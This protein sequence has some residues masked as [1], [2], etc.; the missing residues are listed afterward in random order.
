M[1]PHNNDRPSE[2]WVLFIRFPT[3]K[4]R[5]KTWF[6]GMAKKE[7][8]NKK[9]NNV[10]TIASQEDLK[11]IANTTGTHNREHVCSFFFFAVLLSH[12]KS[13]SRF[14]NAPWIPQTRERNLSQGCKGRWKPRLSQER[15]CSVLA[16]PNANSTMGGHWSVHHG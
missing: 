9:Q 11:L 16:T 3:K 2:C 1:A 4:L 12:K 6:V 14:K 7:K 5:L 15:A 8:G 10:W 13:C